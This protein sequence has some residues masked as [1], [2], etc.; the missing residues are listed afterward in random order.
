M[1][2]CGEFTAL[3]HGS[4]RLY[5]TTD[6]AVLRGALR[7]MRA[8]APG[9]DSPRPRN[10]GA[11]IPTTIGS[12]PTRARPAG[13]KRP[14]G[15]WCCGITCSSWRRR[16]RSSTARGPLLDVG[17]GGGLFLGMMRERGLARGG[18]GLFARGGGHR[19]AAAAGARGGRRSGARPAARRQFRGPH[20]VPR[21]GAPLRSAR[22][23][24]RRRTNC[25]RRTA[26]WW[27]R[28]RTPRP[29]RRA[30]WAA[31]GTAPTSRAT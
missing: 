17:C 18:P 7:R 31:R 25:W 30:C 9:P 21:D 23:P 13:W 15:G 29:G 6:E 3:F 8:A 2:G 11:T 1:C 27:C 19:L 5:H 20:D 10:C 22:V 14:T 4:D 26:A 12:R 24:A 16:W 28:C